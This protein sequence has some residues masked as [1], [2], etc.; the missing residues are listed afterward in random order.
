MKIVFFLLFIANSF[1]NSYSFFLPNVLQSFGKSKQIMIQ[2]N[3]D[4][5]F[6]AKELI[7]KNKLHSSLHPYAE[8]NR[9]LNNKYSLN[10]IN[11]LKKLKYK[12]LHLLYLYKTQKYL[13]TANKPNHKF[14]EYISYIESYYK[15]TLKLFNKNFFNLKNQYIKDYELL[16]NKPS[17]FIKIIHQ[18][19]KDPY[20]VYTWMKL[21]Y[22]AP[23]D[24][25]NK[26]KNLLKEF[27][28]SSIFYPSALL[29]VHQYHPNFITKKHLKRFNFFEQNKLLK[30]KILKQKP[31]NIDLKNLS[32]YSELI[33]Q[34]KFNYDLWY[35]L[36]ESVEYK[37]IAV[38]I[39]NRLP[40]QSIKYQYLS[41][42]NQFSN[43]P[44]KIIKSHPVPIIEGS[45]QL[46]NNYLIHPKLQ[47]KFIKFF[48]QIQKVIKQKKLPKNTINIQF[49]VINKD[50]IYD[51]FAHQ[52]IIN[53]NNILKW[54][55]L[56]VILQAA[57]YLQ[58]SY[59]L[60]LHDKDIFSYKRLPHFV[61]YAYSY[62]LNPNF[63]EKDQSEHVLFP[64]T[65]DSLL[66]FPYQ[67]QNEDSWK[68]FRYQSYLLSKELDFKRFNSSSFKQ[69][70]QYW[71]KNNLNH[72]VYQNKLE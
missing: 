69:F 27:K 67:N 18:R 23:F 29:L 42:M 65:Y 51:P 40:L 32:P 45:I 1:S 7:A 12:D 8:L 61:I 10:I 37:H 71:L 46:S 5:E 26:I 35:Q 2:S 49:N 33:L 9:R 60:T 70:I 54:E 19:K 66:N 13:K 52:I 24:N 16:I 56:K 50:Y 36:L 15:G 63:I 59:Q 25:K 17:K 62:F 72:Y 55:K 43:K 53:Q 48:K 68:A 3:Q 47:N 28:K 39:M 64:M 14:L 57:I 58:L 34:E 30:W 38:R 21:Q 44:L 22:F 6:L 11:T 20:Q 31:I 41:Q 4:L